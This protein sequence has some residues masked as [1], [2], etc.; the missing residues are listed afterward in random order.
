LPP[1]WL[2]APF[3]QVPQSVGRPLAT[4]G[5][6]ELPQFGGRSLIAVDQVVELELVDLASIELGESVPDVFEERAELGLVVGGD[7]FSRGTTF[8]LRAPGVTRGSHGGTLPQRRQPPP[9]PSQ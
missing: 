4:A 3:T 7:Q 9:G 1:V 2:F 6:A 5:P 8:G